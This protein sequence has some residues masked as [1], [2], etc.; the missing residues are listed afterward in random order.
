MV[1]TNPLTGMRDGAAPAIANLGTLVPSE[2]LKSATLTRAAS[3][4]IFA[5]NRL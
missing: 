1:C 5:Q 3:A 2:D 4:R